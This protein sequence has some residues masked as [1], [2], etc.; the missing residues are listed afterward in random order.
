MRDVLVRRGGPVALRDAHVVTELAVPSLR[1]R[2]P[3]GRGAPATT[4]TTVGDGVRQHRLGRLLHATVFLAAHK[5]KPVTFSPTDTP[6]L[7]LEHAEGVV[8]R[9][10]G[11]TA[12]VRPRPATASISSSASDTAH[13]HF[14]IREV[15]AP[16]QLRRRPADDAARRL[17]EGGGWSRTSWC[18]GAGGCVEDQLKYALDLGL[19]AIRL[20][21]HL[22]PDE[23][24]DLAD[25]YGILAFARL[26]DAADK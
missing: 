5:T 9:G 17:V 18:A 16:P 15:K 21:G 25:R 1:L 11:R 19:N 4:S 20:E 8:A 10:H 14:G 12:A 7:R 26:G 23:F 24:F 13:E 2:G 22:E 6:G 3:D